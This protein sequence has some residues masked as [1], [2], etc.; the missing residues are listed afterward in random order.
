M[1]ISDTLESNTS[2]LPKRVALRTWLLFATVVLIFGVPIWYLQLPAQLTTAESQLVGTWTFPLPANPPPNA[3]QQIYE[4]RS[5]R[6]IV[7]YGKSV[8][9]GI[10]TVRGKGTW[11]LDGEML[12]WKVANVDVSARFRAFMDGRPS[13]YESRMRY[14]GVKGDSFFIETTDGSKAPLCRFSNGP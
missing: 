12:V 5:D 1:A 3:I 2:A 8:L 13:S 11:G 14:L 7:K 4:M 6:T 10:M 9:T